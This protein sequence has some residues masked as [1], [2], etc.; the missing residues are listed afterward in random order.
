MARQEKIEAKQ[1]FGWVLLSEIEMAPTQWGRPL[2]QGDVRAIAAGFDPDMIGAVALWSRPDLPVLRGRYVCIDGQHRCAA[3]RLIGYDDQRV[4]ALLYEGLTMETAAELSL[5]LQDRRNLH[6]LDKHRAAA[7]AHERRA[8]E[9]DKIMGYCRVEFVYHARSNDI[10]RVSAVA[11]VYQIWDR[12]G[13]GLERVLSVCSRSWGGTAAGFG[14]SVL[15]LVMIVVCAHDGAVDDMH[16]VETLSARS[17]AQWVIKD[18][19]PRRSLSSLAQDVVVEYNKKVR[20]GNRLVELTP[21][22][23][24]TSAKRMPTP[25]VKG[26]IEGRQTVGASQRR[27]RRM[28]VQT[29]AAKSINTGESEDA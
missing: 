23:Y 1:T 24:E 17:P 7:A 15:K 22:Q 14:S 12:M 21:S 26:K 3:M 5:G 4:P 20:G 8:V 29:K 11:A 27:I 6:A 13:E 9:V 19:S 28:A 18:V 2:R 16:L 25:T 10:G